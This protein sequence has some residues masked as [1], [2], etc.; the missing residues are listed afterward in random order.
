MKSSAFKKR[1]N[2]IMDG[3]NPF[4]AAMKDVKV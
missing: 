2:L 1:C 4:S 3:P